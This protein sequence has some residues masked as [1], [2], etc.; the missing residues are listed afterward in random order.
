MSEL[1]TI[2]E[3]VQRAASY[4][5]RQEGVVLTTFNLNATFL[6]EQALPLLLG[7]EAETVATR[8][9]E[10]HQRLGA[11][12][13]SL[14]YDPSIPP[15][16]SGRYRFVA[17]PVPM[18]GRFF[19]PKLIVIAGRAADDT[20]WVYLAV[21]SANLTLSG[22]GRNAESFGETWI[23]SRQQQTWGALD[24]FLAWLQAHAPLGG[25]RAE[26]DAVARVRA[27]LARMP[28]RRRIVDDGTAPWSGAPYAR[29]YTS[30]THPDGFPSFLQMGRSRRAATL[31]V[32][33]PYWGEVAR[34]VARFNA[35]RTVLVPALSMTTGS[36][37]LAREQAAELPRGV[38]I[39]R[40]TEDNGVRFC[41]M[42]AYGVVHGNRVFTAVGSCNFTHAG[43]A[44]S[45][46]NV[47]AALVFE[48]D[49]NWLPEG[50]LADLTELALEPLPEEEAPDPPPVMIVVAFDWRSR[51]WRWWLDP[52]PRQQGFMLRLPGVPPFAI[53]PGRNERP[54]SPPPSGATFT[55]TYENTEGE[56]TWQGQV[57]ELNLDHS[58]RVYGH[59]L[60]ANEILESWRG[61]APAWGLGGGGGD[62]DSEEDGDGVEREVPAAFD[63]VNLY[64]LY[65]SMGALRTKLSS[66]GAHP[67][68][69]R[70]LL[71]GRPDSVMALAHLA[72]RDG[73][74]PIVRYLV[75]R[76]LC[77]ILGHWA[78]L[79]DSDLVKRVEQ[80]A[81]QA[82]ARTQ[83][84]L[85]AELHGD[86]SK[87]NE[88]LTWFEQRLA[89]L[90]GGAP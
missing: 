3:R 33:S 67:D 78:Q 12:P 69:Q 71:V 57:V 6:E 72:C 76:E 19:H 26:V 8:R 36:L 25:D 84:Q 22:W 64:D 56:Q 48:A 5:L 54:G 15:K 45:G 59:P 28:S 65:R 90:D 63:A 14:F 40:N 73:E 74:A 86:T 11:T 32:Y 55:V 9:A 81:E 2:R 27:A 37:G 82:R 44:G 88:M 29:L 18:R 35:Q 42:K 62:G 7:V 75:L 20:T 89:D 61:R 70:A 39:R 13:C 30:V 85:E 79:L 51:T 21:S 66:L 83:E 47:E 17:R 34:M 60:T 16:L 50:D 53:A 43:L 52:G 41:H 77:G 1:G 80:M 31:W 4:F 87:T 46:G 68:A 49:P 10:T 38:D 24:D 58:T 23:H